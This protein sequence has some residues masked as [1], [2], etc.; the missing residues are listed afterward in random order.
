MARLFCRFSLFNYRFG[1]LNHRL[2]GLGLLNLINFL[3]FF[4]DRLNRL[5]IFM[6][7]LLVLFDVSLFLWG[8]GGTSFALLVFLSLFLE[9]LHELFNLLDAFMAGL[10]SEFVLSGSRL[11]AL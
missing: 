11:L 9:F 3:F 4:I 8:F 1:L 10:N 7:L 5:L 2:F 6:M